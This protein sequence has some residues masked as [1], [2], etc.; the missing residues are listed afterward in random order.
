MNSLII[1]FYKNK[2]KIQVDVNVKWH[3]RSDIHNVLKVTDNSIEVSFNNLLSTFRNIP[4]SIDDDCYCGKGE[5]LLPLPLI[6][7]PPKT[8]N[9]TINT[10]NPIII[11]GIGVVYD[12]ITSEDQFNKI[13][14]RCYFMTNNFIQYENIYFVYQPNHKQILQDMIKQFYDFFMNCN[15][16][17]D[18][19]NK[20]VYTLNIV[21]SNELTTGG[22]G[23]IS[24]GCFIYTNPNDNYTIN[25]TKNKVIYHESFHHFNPGFGLTAKSYEGMW[26]REGFCEFFYAYI[27]YGLKSKEFKNFVDDHRK[28][29]KSNKYKNLTNQDLVNKLEHNFNDDELRNLPYSRGC[30]FAEWLYENNPN[31]LNIYKKI[32][33][34]INNGRKFTEEEIGKL[35]DSKHY[36]DFIVNGNIIPIF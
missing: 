30:M 20:K 9:V 31:F 5:F 8:L 23:N 1:H 19:V 15:K 18:I 6:D 4:L 21:T 36:N 33:V 11:S 22:F 32:I 28:A 3:F 29:Y 17:F 14:R 34:D 16:F 2:L 25:L 12:T 10:T 35:L 26:F 7:N 27:L 13:F 24:N